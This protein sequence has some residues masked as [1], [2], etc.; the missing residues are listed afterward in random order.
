MKRLTICLF[1]LY[2]TGNVKAQTFIDS[3][4]TARHLISSIATIIQEQLEQR[5]FTNITNI[6]DGVAP[7]ILFSLSSG[8]PGSNVDIA[9]REFPGA[10]DLNPPLYVVDGFIYDGPLSLINPNDIENIKILKDAAACAIYGA[11]AQSGVIEITTKR[12]S[13]AGKPVL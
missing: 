3:D 8:Q 7:G 11:S 2:L 4:S 10:A 13:A 6:F 9:I 1:C 12:G 5:A